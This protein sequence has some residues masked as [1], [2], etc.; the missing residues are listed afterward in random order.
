MVE[1]GFEPTNLLVASVFVHISCKRHIWNIYSVYQFHYS[2]IKIS[3]CPFPSGICGLNF[4]T[5]NLANLKTFPRLFT[6]LTV[7]TYPLGRDG[8]WQHSLSTSAF[9]LL[10]SNLCP[11]Y[12]QQID[13]IFKELVIGVGFE[14]TKIILWLFFYTFSCVPYAIKNIISILSVYQFHHPIMLVR[15]LFAIVSHPFHLDLYLFTV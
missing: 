4:T 15:A 9:L 7:N 5:K 2:T 11:I 13:N 14:P 10:S 12:I 8:L 1:V 6:H 3:I